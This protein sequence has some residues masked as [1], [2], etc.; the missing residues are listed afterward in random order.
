M[1]LPLRARI[2]AWYFAVLIVSFAAF[3]WISD[4]GFQ[5]SIETTLNDASPRTSAEG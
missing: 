5:R 3:A 4:Y 2:T 1:K